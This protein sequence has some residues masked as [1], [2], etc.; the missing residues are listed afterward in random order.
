VQL[1]VAMQNTFLGLHCW[2]CQGTREFHFKMHV[3]LSRAHLSLPI[4]NFKMFQM[5]LVDK[6][7]KQI[8]L[9]SIGKLSCKCIY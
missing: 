6:K 8:L 5:L 3:F 2:A 1:T 7:G 4:P 9:D